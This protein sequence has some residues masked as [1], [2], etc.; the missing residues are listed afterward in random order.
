MFLNNFPCNAAEETAGFI[1]KVHSGSSL[2]ASGRAPI[3]VECV[4]KQTAIHPDDRENCITEP[5]VR[6]PIT[7]SKR[8]N[9]RVTKKLIP[10]KEKRRTSLQGDLNVLSSFNLF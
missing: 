3:M 4:F 10:M 8:F 5:N 7:I 9:A 1:P 2:T 6:E